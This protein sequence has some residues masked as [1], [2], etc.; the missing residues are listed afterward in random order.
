[1]MVDARALFAHIAS[2]L[3]LRAKRDVLHGFNISGL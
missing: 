1:M 3:N 2:D